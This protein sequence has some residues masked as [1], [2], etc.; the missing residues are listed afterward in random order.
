MHTTGGWQGSASGQCACTALQTI[1]TPV[2][3]P[4]QLG[5]KKK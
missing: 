2:D 5:M 3:Q 4:L 1:K